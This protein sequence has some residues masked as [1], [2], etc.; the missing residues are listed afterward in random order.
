MRKLIQLFA[1]ASGTIG[2]VPAGAHACGDKFLIVGRCVN[3]GQTHAAMHPGSILILWIPDSKAT[4]AI[5]DPELQEALQEAGHRVTVIE[6]TPQFDMAK[7]LGQYNMVLVDIADAD[8]VRLDVSAAAAK[9]VVV[10]VMYRASKAEVAL[11]Q[12][13]YR[14]AL[15]A[16]T[17]LRRSRVLAVIDDAMTLKH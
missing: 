8:R 9:T 1:L 17:P 5:R 6:D 3:Y 16:S 11:A 12:Q 2:F 14:C 10:P 4:T 15:N 7:K 13:N